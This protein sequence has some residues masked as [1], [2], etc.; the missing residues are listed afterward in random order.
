MR[1][2]YSLLFLL[3]LI[4]FTAFGQETAKLYF[5][6][7]EYQIQKKVTEETY[8]LIVKIDSLK[9][10]DSTLALYKVSIV[11]NDEMSTLPECD[12]I[13][14]NN[15]FNLKGNQ[16]EH[17]FYLTINGDSI[18]DRD[19]YLYFSILVTKDNKAVAIN[20]SKENLTQKIKIISTKAINAYNY[21][22]Y[23]GTNFDLVDGIQAKNLFFA[24]N[25]FVPPSTEKRSL[26]FNLI[27]YGN[28]TLT[29]TD[30][31]GQARFASKI[32]G[33]P[34]DSARTYYEEG[35][36]TVSRVSDNLGASFS[37]LWRMGK[38]SDGNRPTQVYYAPQFEF[39]WRRTNVTTL[40]S[41]TRLIDSVDR[42]NRPITGPIYLTQPN[43]SKTYNI[44]D[45]YV[46]GLGFLLNHNNNHISI[47]VQASTGVTYRYTAQNSSSN[48]G[49]SETPYDRKLNYFIFVRAYITEPITG[50]TLGAEITNN[51]IKKSSHQPYY[52]VTLSKA[53]NLNA[54]SGVFRPVVTR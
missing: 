26:G 6:K 5:E 7:D 16:S 51:Y 40:Y 42:R 30:T 14:E 24:S 46:G 11:V 32:V 20:L 17:T 25:L 23:I 48:R 29:L 49:T 50:L 8:R 31:S 10:P 41:D 38:I 1:K 43:E 2:I 3:P 44:Y 27:L 19:R 28:R 36:K 4:G 13:L 53:F 37:P 45:I 34:G 22:A 12:Y 18:V 21:L 54:L 52:N 9:I 33:L 39:I 35:L 47:R 15:T